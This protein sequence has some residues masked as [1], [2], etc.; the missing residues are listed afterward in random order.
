[1]LDDVVQVLWD[2]RERNAQLLQ[3]QMP[4]CRNA[5]HKILDDLD[6]THEDPKRPGGALGHDDLL[7][8]AKAF[9]LKRF[10]GS[11][12]GNSRRDLINT[13]TGKM[14]LSYGQ[15]LGFDFNAGVKL[16]GAAIEDLGKDSNHICVA[17]FIEYAFRQADRDIG[18]TMGNPSIGMPAV[19]N[20]ELPFS[21]RVL[22]Y[23]NRVHAPLGQISSVF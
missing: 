9:F 22:V 21:K 19:S 4:P 13:A 18:V 16:R 12:L 15:Y 3:P 6:H 20:V 23:T 5:P 2:E 17:Q 1:G 14:A 10:A 11:L 8:R 7:I